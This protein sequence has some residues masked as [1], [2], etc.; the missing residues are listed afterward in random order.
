MASSHAR[1]S[2]G[3]L[4]KGGSVSRQLCGINHSSKRIR[5]PR[6]AAR[7]R[8]VRVSA[9]AALSDIADGGVRKGT[10]TPDVTGVANAWR[11]S[12]SRLARASGRR[13]IRG[14]LPPQRGASEVQKARGAEGLRLS[15]VPPRSAIRSRA[16]H[17]L[18]I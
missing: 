10:G 9:R 17:K 13:P 7:I 15:V 18:G 2:D 5:R 1:T 14:E 16:V 12:H 11:N 4:E 8:C 6:P 3:Y